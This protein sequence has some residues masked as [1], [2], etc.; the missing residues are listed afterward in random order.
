LQFQTDREGD[1]ASL[2]IP[3][4]PA[5]APIIFRR[6][7]EPA[8]RARAFLEPLTGLYHRCGI[9]FRIVLDD[10]DRLIMT[11]GSGADER[12]LPCHGGTFALAGDHYF[13]LEFR[14]DASGAVDA[15]LFHEATGIYLVE[16][17][18]VSAR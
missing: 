11:R 6:M 4:E 15:M 10:S 18:P 16:R 12:L 2:A 13:K 9:L 8:T 5:V 14:R 3:L 1:I 17:V 7:A